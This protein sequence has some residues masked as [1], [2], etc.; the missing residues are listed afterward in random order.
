MLIKSRSISVII[1]CYKDAATLGRALESIYEQT[2][3]VN[4]V[5]V[6]ND[7]SPETAAIELVL[8]SYPDVLYLK[9]SVNLGLAATRNVGVRNAK[10]DIVTFLDAD[11]SLHPQKIELQL[12]LFKTERV[13]SCSTQRVSRN[14]EQVESVKYKGSVPYRRIS[15]SIRSLVSNHITGA[16]MMIS[17]ELFNSMGGY[18]ETLKSCE[19]FDFWLRLLNHGVDVVDIQ[20]PLYYYAINPSGLTSN[21]QKISHWE[22]KVIKKF[23]ADNRDIEIYKRYEPIVLVVWL[24][25]HCVRYRL[26]G[27]TSYKTDIDNNAYLLSDLP[28]ARAILWLFKWMRMDVLLAVL[29]K[30]YPGKN[31]F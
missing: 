15:M 22:L 30:A 16:A 28:V 8:R 13:I 20:L 24:S 2:H 17:R 1:P 14:Y 11:D 23:F 29:V 18:D 31:S 7:A 9:N 10:S 5:I 19:D 12:A 25:R 27:D 6:I 4:E 3:H 21:I 26:C